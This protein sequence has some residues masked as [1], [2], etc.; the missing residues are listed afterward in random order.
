MKIGVF[1]SGIGGLT[2]LKELV[3]SFPNNEFIYL[4][5]MLNSPFGEKTEEQIIDITKNILEFMK[6]K[7]VDVIICACGTIS[8]ISNDV[9]NMF[10]TDNNVHLFEMTDGIKQSLMKANKQ[11]ILLLATTA[12]I[13]KGTFEKNIKHSCN[14]KVVLEACPIFVT[15]LEADISEE[16]LINEALKIHLEKTNSDIDAIVLGCTHYGLLKEYIKRYVPNIEIFEAG[17]CLV[18]RQDV[19][20]IFEKEKTDDE[21]VVHIYTTKITKTITNMS[22]EIFNSEVE[23]V[24]I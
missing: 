10:S 21:T 4:A 11:N 8:G 2:V 18:E 7:K 5:D 14:V 19:K 12:T 15:L 23:V 20:N 9:L 1:D 16:T 6:N 17:K 13:N 3:N 24:K 22:K